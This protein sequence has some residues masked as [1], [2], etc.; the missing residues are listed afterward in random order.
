[1]TS[2]VPFL[3]GQERFCLAF[4]TRHRW[5]TAK[6]AIFARLRPLLFW[7][8]IRSRLLHPLNKKEKG[9]GN[10]TAQRREAMGKK[11]E[12]RFAGF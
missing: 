3:H 1:M 4:G 10:S 12:G 6:W 9:W 7:H 2:S 11:V 8:D 5:K